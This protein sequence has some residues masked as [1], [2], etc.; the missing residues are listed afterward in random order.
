MDSSD[1]ED[2]TAEWA[3][4]VAPAE[5]PPGFAYAPCPPMATEEEQRALVGRRVLVA[6]D[7]KQ[8][9]GWFLG[10]VRLHRGQ[11]GLPDGQLQGHLPQEGD[12]RRAVWG[13]GLRALAGQLRRR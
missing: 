4:S 5:A 1:E 8:A 11:E 6:H 7:S 10:K 13:C 2:D 9:T 12:R 3:C